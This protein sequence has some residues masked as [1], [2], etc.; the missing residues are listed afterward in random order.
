MEP[1][2]EVE[3]GKNKLKS[4]YL[5]ILLKATL[6]CIYLLFSFPQGDENR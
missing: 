1:A 3:G 5:L 6:F 4:Q 2:Q